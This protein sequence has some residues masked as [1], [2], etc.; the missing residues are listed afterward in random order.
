V[1]CI[2][3]PVSTALMVAGVVTSR[4]E[5]ESSARSRSDVLSVG[6]ASG[7]QWPG[8]WSGSAAANGTGVG[9]FRGTPDVP[10]W[11]TGQCY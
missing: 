6:A 10:R 4:D 3:R 1:G 7:D 2:P 8:H 9:R 5:G 11:P